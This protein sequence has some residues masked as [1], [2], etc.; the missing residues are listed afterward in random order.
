MPSLNAALNTILSQW[1]HDVMLQRKTADGFA[2]KL[3]QF[4]VRHMYPANR[5]LPRVRSEEPE[6]IVNTVDLIYFFRADALPKEGDRIYDHDPAIGQVT[7]IIDYALPMRGL[8]GKVVFYQA[9]VT[10]ESPN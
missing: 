4:T 6:G 10:R 2:N 3:E 8:G 9:G 1:G 5:G 7:Y